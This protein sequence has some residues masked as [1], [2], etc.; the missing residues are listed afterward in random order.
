MGRPSVKF[1]DGS[2][3]EKPNTN[4]ISVSAHPYL[5][6]PFKQIS[7]SFCKQLIMTSYRRRRVTVITALIHTIHIHSCSQSCIALPQACVMSITVLL[8]GVGYIV[9]YSPAFEACIDNEEFL[10]YCQYLHCC[11]YLPSCLRKFCSLPQV[12]VGEKG[13]CYSS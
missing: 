11:T 6:V 7:S 8:P 10:H 12:L 2:V 4:R 9:T 3:F 5:W 1:L 13:F